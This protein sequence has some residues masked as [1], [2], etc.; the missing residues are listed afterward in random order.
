M[1]GGSCAYCGGDSRLRELENINLTEVHLGVA[2]CTNT[3][4]GEQVRS[5]WNKVDSSHW[6]SIQPTSTHN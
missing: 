2:L 1:L 6:F 4:D 3:E 5:C